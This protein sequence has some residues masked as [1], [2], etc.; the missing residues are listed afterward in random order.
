MKPVHFPLKDT[1]YLS[2]LIYLFGNEKIK[3]VLE[4]IDRLNRYNPDNF[5]DPETWIEKMQKKI[6]EF[7]QEHFD[8]FVK[9]Y[10]AKD[11]AQYF[12]VGLFSETWFKFIY[13]QIK[14]PL[15]WIE[16]QIRYQCRN[17]PLTEEEISDRIFAYKTIHKTDNIVL[18]KIHD[19]C[20]YIFQAHTEEGN[21]YKIG[22]TNNLEARKRALSREY[23]HNLFL[24]NAINCEDSKRA[25]KLEKE[26]HTDLFGKRRF[27][28]KSME[29]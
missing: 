26:I 15:I 28:K 20:V 5:T 3:E 1:K 16:E 25:S 8:Y 23:E 12:T 2:Q 4:E 22:K 29:V 27:V 13:E 24:V 14:N 19:F 21:F 18:N 6:P 10:R 17:L 11:N 7:R 9:K